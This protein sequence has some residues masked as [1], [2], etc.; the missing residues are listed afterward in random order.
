MTALS[1]AA[2]TEALM[3]RHEAMFGS[4]AAPGAAA[5]RAIKPLLSDMPAARAEARRLY[6]RRPE[7]RA[8]FAVEG[9]RHLPDVIDMLPGTWLHDA[10]SVID[11][12]PH[13][14]GG[15]GDVLTCL[16]QHA[17]IIPP[18]SAGW[19]AVEMLWTGPHL[20]DALRALRRLVEFEISSRRRPAVG[21]LA[22]DVDDYESA[23]QSSTALEIDLRSYMR[24]WMVEIVRRHAAGD[25]RLDFVGEAIGVMESGDVMAG[26]FE[27]QARA[28]GLIDGGEDERPELT[29][30]GYRYIFDRVLCLPSAVLPPVYVVDDGDGG[31]RFETPGVLPFGCPRSLAVL[32]AGAGGATVRRPLTEAFRFTDPVDAERF[33]T[34]VGSDEF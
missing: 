17:L 6:D 21:M 12:Q 14:V 9:Y 1:D 20:L 11:D 24:R 23:L 10:L 3:R 27:E 25:P 19:S 18:V 31:A 7:F 33:A 13:V 28:F 22:A 4:R 34:L 5:F 32:A 8:E 29:A 16:I 26:L 2:L 15:C 30:R